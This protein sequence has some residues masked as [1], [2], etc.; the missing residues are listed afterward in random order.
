[1]SFKCGHLWW[2]IL[3][4]L[5]VLIKILASHHNKDV[6][7]SVGK[8]HPFHQ[9][10]RHCWSGCTQY[11]TFQFSSQELVGVINTYI[12]KNLLEETS[13]W[14]QCCC[15]SLYH[16]SKLHHVYECVSR[17]SFWAYHEMDNIKRL[18]DIASPSNG[19][20]WTLDAWIFFAN[21]LQRTSRSIIVGVVID[22]ANNIWLNQFYI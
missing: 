11:V 22:H 9:W 12:A 2:N 21:S 5:G 1:M 16:W 18:F 3:L 8:L 13:N 15:R 6:N 7:P 10:A 14:N 17:S 19:K 4:G 20:W